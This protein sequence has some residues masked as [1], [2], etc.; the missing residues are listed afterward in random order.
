MKNKKRYLA[1]FCFLAAFLL[2]TIAVT[3][4]DIQPIGPNGSRVGLSGLNGWMHNLTG[5]HMWLYTLTDWL[6]LIPLLFILGF[7]ALGLTQWIHAKSLLKVD[8]SLLTLGGFYAAVLGAY[9]F[10]EKCIVNY[11][12]VLIEGIL[13][14]SYPSSTTVLVISVMSTA[15]MELRKRIH[16]PGKRTW[17]SR[18][19]AVFTVF[20]VMGRFLSGVHWFTDI[21]GGILLSIGLVLLYAGFTQKRDC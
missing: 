19:I 15:G 7:A 12:P 3:V 16:T 13:E 14:A 11:R 8:R 10:F 18:M 21:A 5:V 2:W 20:M 1:A 6:S 9:L 4:I 17:L